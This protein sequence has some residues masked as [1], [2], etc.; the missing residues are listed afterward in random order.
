MRDLYTYFK[1]N[2]NQMFFFANPNFETTRSED[3]IEADIIGTGTGQ[4]QQQCIDV[5]Y[6]EKLICNRK[7]IGQITEIWNFFSQNQSSN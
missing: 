2:R 5:K 3:C 6:R 4:K 7:Y 1:Y